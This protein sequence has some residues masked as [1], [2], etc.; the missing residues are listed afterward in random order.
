[1]AARV[2]YNDAELHQLLEAPGGPVGRDL[3]RRAGNV[4]VRA[5]QLTNETLNRSTRPGTHY[6]DAHVTGLAAAPL[7]AFA[8][9]DADH[10]MILNV[11][12]RPHIIRARNAPYLVFYSP[13]AGRIIRTKEV[14]HPGT[15]AYA[16]L[17]SALPAA[18]F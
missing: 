18:A 9:N 14:R 10:A 11:G 15:R 5:E 1:M 6:H 16:L 7:M 8:G 17:A 12:S 2:V 3:L 4:R 13:R